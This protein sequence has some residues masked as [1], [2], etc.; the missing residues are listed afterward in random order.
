MYETKFYKMDPKHGESFQ[1]AKTKNMGTLNPEE[2]EWVKNE[3]K[4]ENSIPKPVVIRLEPSL[5]EKLAKTRY[6]ADELE[7]KL[8]ILRQKFDEKVILAESTKKE[9]ERRE[10]Q[11]IHSIQKIEGYMQEMYSLKH[12][13]DE[14]YERFGEMVKE[15]ETREQNLLEQCLEVSI[16]RNTASNFLEVFQPVKVYLEDVVYGKDIDKSGCYITQNI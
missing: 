5:A 13:A 3:I 10:L 16:K 1:N 9:L 7:E 4:T 8:E 15:S 11:L 12:V 2:T 6:V 14:M